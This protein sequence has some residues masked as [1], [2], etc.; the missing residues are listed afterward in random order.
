MDALLPS[1]CKPTKQSRAASKEQSRANSEEVVGGGAVVA[2]PKLAKRSELFPQTPLNVNL[3]QN[4]NS[5]SRGSTSQCSSRSVRSSSMSQSGSVSREA[6]FPSSLIKR[7]DERERV[8][9]DF[10]CTLITPPRPTPARHRGQ[11]GS[12][13]HRRSSHKKRES[14]NAKSI[15]SV[16]TPMFGVDDE[17]D[18]EEDD[19]NDSEA[20]EYEIECC[21]IIISY[22]S[23]LVE[24]IEG[25]L[26][27]DAELIALVLFSAPL[28][29]H[30]F[31]RNAVTVEQALVMSHKWHSIKMG[32]RDA[33][34]SM[35]EGERRVVEKLFAHLQADV[36]AATYANKNLAEIW[37]RE[38]QQEVGQGQGQGQTDMQI[39]DRRQRQKEEREEDEEYDEDE[40][41]VDID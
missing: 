35:E 5:H 41:I 30:E 22:I 1:H 11:N 7:E 32:R 26:L 12:V 9:A 39:Q 8:S 18:E 2:Y 24:V 13:S 34:Q 3:S 16:K 21:D 17:D 40:G 20:T 10:L 23:L 15:K 4:S 14:A 25:A 37:K 29:R 6:V 33:T 36:L 28:L 38:Q 31:A 19:E 27:G